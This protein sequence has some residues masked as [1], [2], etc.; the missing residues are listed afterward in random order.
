MAVAGAECNTVIEIDD[1]VPSETVMKERLLH[2]FEAVIARLTE[3]LNGQFPRPWMT[4]LT[5]PLSANV[6]IVGKNQ[7]KGYGCGH[8]SHK[9]HVDALFNRSGESCRRV[10]GEM[11]GYRPSPTRQNIDYFRSVL[12]AEGI[13]Q[14]LET[15]VICYSTPMSSDL[16]LPNHRGGAV[17]GTEIFLA[18][19]HFVKPK[20]LVVH[21]SGTRDTLVKL[22]KAPLP[23]PSITNNDPVPSV[24]G[25]M[26]IFVIPSLAP[27]QWNHWHTQASPYLAKVAIA[28]AS[29]LGGHASNHSGNLG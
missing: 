13:T 10:Y 19:L 2:E 6:F 14:V 21:G 27:P 12:A 15:N 17:R 9:R 11:T 3:P 1:T 8:I 23:A 26:S 28:A 24:I 5:N 16:R 22:L 4:D 7:A 20:V 18:L 29:V 25:E